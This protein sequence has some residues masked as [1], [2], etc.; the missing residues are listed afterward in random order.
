VPLD[1]QPVHRAPASRLLGPDRRNVV[2]GVTRRH[3]CTAPGALVEVDRHSPFMCHRRSWFYV[4]RSTFF[5]LNSEFLI[6]NSPNLTLVRVLAHLAG[7]HDQATI[8]VARP[9]DLD[10]RRRPRERAGI[11]LGHRREDPDRV[12]AAAA[13]VTRERL[14]P[15]P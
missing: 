7:K 9:R 13:R 14:V 15:L 8:A 5:V 11:R 2:F 4:L 10:A 3:A 12:H 1:A 6:P